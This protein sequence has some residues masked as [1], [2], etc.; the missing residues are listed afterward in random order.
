MQPTQANEK[1][2][3]QSKIGDD[4][5]LDSEE[6]VEF[7]SEESVEEDVEDES[8]EENVSNEEKY[9][10]EAVEYGMNK[11]KQLYEVDEPKLYNMGKSNI[12]CG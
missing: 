6:S 9:I 3:I 5:D 2:G 11:M 1:I 12:K 8:S 7:D 4:F 10:K